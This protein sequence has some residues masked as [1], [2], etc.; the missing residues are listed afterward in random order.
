M[1]LNKNERIQYLGFDDLRF[2]AI[3]ILFISIVSD[4]IV[5]DLSI[6]QLPFKLAVFSWSVS[7]F[8]SIT[9][10]FTIRAVLISLRKRYPSF[11]DDTKRILLFFL[12]IVS[13]VVSVDFF[14]GKMLLGIFR[15][16]GEPANRITQ[17]KDLAAIIVIT[18]M[19][20]AIYE[21]VY[22]YVRL[23]ES[24]KKEEQSK[25]IIIQAQLDALK[26]Q[27]SPH[28]LFNSL[29]TLCDIID[30][31]S[32]E[33]A[34]GFV[35]NLSD[36]YRF[37]LEAEKTNTI[38]LKKEIKFTKSYIYIQLERFGENLKV[39]WNISEDKLETMIVP[40]SLQLL[41]E[42]AIK[43]NVVSISNPLIIT[44]E[45][46]NDYLVVRNK[47]Q[48]KSTKVPSTKIGLQN[49]KK[50]YSLISDKLPIIEEIS[51]E[52]KVSLPLLT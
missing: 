28:F 15:Y 25:Q 12:A 16:F 5:S 4:Y 3:G 44:V 51:D 50:R 41:I 40:M 24:V 34:K 18:T 31:D 14:G 21:A 17:P 48:L 37:I 2:V 10:W 43:H 35:N 27:V 52:F 30:H 46:A 13:I 39:N 22:Y 11:K 42:N 45:I 49:I 29:N 9:N 32:K 7:L 47:I 1:F 36:V 20:M 23:K 26:N 8:F 6:Y 33:D 38:S 19:I